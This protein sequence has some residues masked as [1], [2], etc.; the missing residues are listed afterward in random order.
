M[1]AAFAL[2]MAPWFAYNYVTLGR[3]TLSPPAASDEASGK[4]HGRPPGRVACRT[5]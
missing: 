5:N 1:I 4:V 2:T 3:F